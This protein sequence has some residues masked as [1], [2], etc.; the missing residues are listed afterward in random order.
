[1]S[2]FISKDIRPVVGKTYL[3]SQFSKKFNYSLFDTNFLLVFYVLWVFVYSEY[4]TLF[5]FF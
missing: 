2:S 1:M 5:F 3:E 4:Y